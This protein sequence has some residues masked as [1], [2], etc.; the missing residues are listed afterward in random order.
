MH[1]S[2]TLDEIF[3]VPIDE[4]GLQTQPIEK[5]ELNLYLEDETRIYNKMKL[6]LY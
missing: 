6:L 4:N 5:S 3:D 1:L 2:N